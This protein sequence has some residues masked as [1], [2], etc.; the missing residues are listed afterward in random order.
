MASRSLTSFRQAKGRSERLL[1]ISTDRRLRPINYADA[2]PSLH[3][4]L[5]S[6]VSAWEAY[7]EA[8]TIEAIDVVA[9]GASAEVLLLTTLIRA[10]AKRAIEKFNTPNAE[11][12]RDLLLKYTGFDSFPH[13]QSARLSLAAHLARARLNEILQVRHAFAHGYR[14]PAYAWTTRYGIQNRLTKRAVADAAIL[15]DDFV[16]VVDL[17]LGRHVKTA[18]PTRTVW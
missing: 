9:A 11:N 13:M 6:T 4:A 5:A 14:I 17:E 18:F 7:I 10:E 12:C 8:V 3:A 16:S 1:A 2:E 15:I